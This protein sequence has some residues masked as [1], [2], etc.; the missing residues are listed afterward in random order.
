MKAGFDG[1][2]QSIRSI[3]VDHDST[4][5][6][7][8]AG[9]DSIDRSGAPIYQNKGGKGP[10]GQA[11][12]EE[13]RPARLRL[14][15]CFADRLAHQTPTDRDVIRATIDRSIDRSIDSVHISSIECTIE[16]P[17]TLIERRV[18]PRG[19]GSTK[20]GSLSPSL[21]QLARDEHRRGRRPPRVTSQI[22]S[23]QGPGQI[24]DQIR[25]EMELDLRICWFERNRCIVWGERGFGTKRQRRLRGE[26]HGSRREGWLGGLICLMKV[27]RQAGVPRWNCRA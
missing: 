27:Q 19:E 7:P 10:V 9:C 16:R 8:N 24:V 15:R 14:P 2:P 22:G 3:P 1:Q 12:P 25:C 5:C 4:I 11:R 6:R 13:G 26:R 21:V 18:Q 17:P 23:H 20:E